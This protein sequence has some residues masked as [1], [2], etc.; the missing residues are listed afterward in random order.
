MSAIDRTFD[1]TLCSSAS[2][3]STFAI[4]INA[5][6]MML[7]KMFTDNSASDSAKLSDLKQRLVCVQL[8]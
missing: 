7:N 1:P 4:L 8:G 5:Y 3:S 2:G 6:I